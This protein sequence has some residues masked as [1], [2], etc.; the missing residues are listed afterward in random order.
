MQNS[1]NARTFVAFLFHFNLYHHLTIAFHAS[2][3]LHIM[4]PPKR[5]CD[6]RKYTYFFPSYIMIPPKPG[7]GFHGNLTRQSQASSKS[8]ELASDA[9][10]TGSDSDIHEFW[11]GQDPESSREDD[12]RRKK[13]WRIGAEEIANLRDVAKKF[14]GTHNFHNFTVLGKGFKD[15]TNQRYMKQIEVCGMGPQLS[16]R[17]LRVYKTNALI[18]SAR[19]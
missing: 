7:S 6:S 16:T 2:V 4:L 5:S 11:R 14:E 3:C 9:V 10:D 1:F 15:R 17:L 12:M 13:Q 18:L 19:F 8:S